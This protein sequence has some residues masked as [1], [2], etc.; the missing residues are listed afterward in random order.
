MHDNDLGQPDPL[1]LKVFA[2][3][4]LPTDERLRYLIEFVAQLDDRV[5]EAESLLTEI[6][7]AGLDELEN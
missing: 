3:H 2:G 7:T 5:K 1:R 6:A 4:D